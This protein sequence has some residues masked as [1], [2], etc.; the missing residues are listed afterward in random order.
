[1]LQSVDFTVE[2]LENVVVR[3]SY[4]KTIARTDYGCCSRDK[5]TGTPPRAIALGGVATERKTT[6]G[7]YRSNH[8]TSYIA[9][10]VLR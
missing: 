10:G 3:A 9:R 6:P 8:K 1:M 2:L 5:T 7:W 4:S